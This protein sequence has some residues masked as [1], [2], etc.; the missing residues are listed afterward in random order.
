MKLQPTLLCV[1]FLVT[2]ICLQG[3]RL[4]SA[5]ARSWS[6]DLL[7][8]SYRAPF[9]ATPTLSSTKSGDY[10]ITGFVVGA[11]ALG[12]LGAWVGLQSCNDQPTPIGA[13]GGQACAAPILTLGF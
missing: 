8:Q 9:P 2:P 1:V 3:Q 10:G 12:A 11:I 7:R 13:G 5:P 4:A 6:P